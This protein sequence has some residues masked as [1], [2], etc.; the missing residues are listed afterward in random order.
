M[1]V[2]TMTEFMDDLA[3]RI[4]EK[5]NSIYLS[6]KY[7]TDEAFNEYIKVPQNICDYKLLTMLVAH[8]HVREKILNMHSILDEIT[9]YTSSDDSE[10]EVLEITPLEKNDTQYIQYTYEDGYIIDDYKE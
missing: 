10:E 1:S 8:E 7:T 3:G 6:G 4:K 9:L 2:Y 5:F